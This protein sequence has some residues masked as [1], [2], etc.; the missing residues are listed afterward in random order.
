MFN[1]KYEII[2]ESYLENNDIIM[3]IEKV[4]NLIDSYIGISVSEK[5]LL[6]EVFT[7][8]KLIEEILDH[9]PK[10]VW[11]NPYL[12]W[13]DPAN[14]I[15]NFPIVIV[16]R[17]LEGLKDFEPDYDK[18]YKHIMENMIYVC[19]INPKNMWIFNNLFDPDNKL[20]LNTYRGSFLEEGFD[21]WMKDVWKVEKFDIGVGNPP[22]TQMIDMDFIQKLYKISNIVLFVHPSTW[23]L[24]EK[25]KQKKFI[26]TKELIKNHIDTIKLFNGNK[27]FNI[28]LF[29]PCVITYINKNKITKGI[30][31]INK[32]N[33]INLIYD[34]I[35][36]I[37]KY[38]NTDIYLKL[39]EKI[40]TKS[41]EDNL[42]QHKNKVDGDFYVNTA[43]I[44]GNV[45]KNDD[46][47]VQDD[48]YTLITKDT[49]V[50]DK[51]N[52]YMFFSFEKYNDAN[53]FIEYLKTKFCR[54]CLSI[55]KNNSQ[56][57]RG[58][59]EII[60]WLDFSKKWG[61]TELVKEFNLSQEE[62]NFID[63]FIPNYYI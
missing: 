23:I 42:L 35:Y 8:F 59:L 24:D 37:N 63:R 39:K 52:K 40:K 29:V 15:G 4:I 58:E 62:I 45:I 13:L 16:K 31:C 21:N 14:G 46:K 5:K 12:K 55:Y 3:Y 49:I 27:M 6:G 51:K 48:F 26:K 9:L 19:D 54:F 1:R 22:Y 18:R 2:L 10:E 7:P 36:Q 41:I 32:I 53:N 38:S 47:M 44:R 34:N 20:K 61:D 11:S 50:T 28:A 60:P 30:K 56:L 17:L 33:N 57:D 25:S 43:Q